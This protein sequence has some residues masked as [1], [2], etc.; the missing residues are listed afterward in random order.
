MED[1]LQR[2]AI[3][4]QIANLGQ[5]PIQILRKKHPR[6]GPPIPIAHPLRFAPSS[7][8]LSS[9]V[10][11]TSTHP[12]AVLYVGISESHVVLVNQGLTMSVKLWL[13]TQLASSGNFTFSSSQFAIGADVVPPR[14]IGSP[15]AENI[16]LGAQCFTTMQTPSGNFLVSCG[17]WENNFQLISLND[18]RLVQS[19]RQHKDVVS[20]VYVNLK[21]DLPTYQ[22]ASIPVSIDEVHYFKRAPA[23]NQLNPNL[24]NPD[25]QFGQRSASGSRASFPP[26]KESAEMESPTESNDNSNTSLVGNGNGKGKGS[27]QTTVFVPHKRHKCPHPFYWKIPADINAEETL[28]TL[29]YANRTPNIQ[30]KPMVNRDP[31]SSEMLK[32]RQQLEYLQAELC[33]RCGGSTIELQVN[34]VKGEDVVCLIKNSATLSGSLFTLHVSQICIELPTFTDKDKEVN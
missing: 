28:N 27:L 7:I 34:E 25:Q 5:T 4:D 17:D 1:E 33:A 11:S 20:Y 23:L 19:V 6:W 24:Q 30:N 8:T 3:E 32:M 15:L 22:C 9:I 26:P 31:V 29:K 12:S 14:R 21:A 18:G 16:E 2:G 13:T 10:S